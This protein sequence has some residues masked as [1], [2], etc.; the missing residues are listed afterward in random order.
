MRV[1]CVVVF[2]ECSGARA[3]T[4]AVAGTVILFLRVR[5]DCPRAFQAHGR[6]TAHVTVHSIAPQRPR[7]P[8]NTR[9]TR[10]KRW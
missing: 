3:F 2:E 9:K 8:R 4:P 6:S 5:D 7:V 1:R 10:F